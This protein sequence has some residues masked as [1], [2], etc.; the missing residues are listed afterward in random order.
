[1]VNE[2]RRRE[3]RVGEGEAEEKERIEEGG[4][5]T[6]EWYSKLRSV[7]HVWLLSFIVK[8]GTNIPDT[9]NPLIRFERGKSNDART[10]NL[11]LTKLCSNYIFCSLPEIF[12]T[13]SI[14]EQLQIFTH[15]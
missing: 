3:M 2:E 1:V 9:S 14:N 10:Q 8:S 6:L 7:F 11:P 12:T 13:T 4:G 15:F 5:I